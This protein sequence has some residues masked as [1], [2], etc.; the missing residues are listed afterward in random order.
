MQQMGRTEMIKNNL[1]PCFERPFEIEYRFDEVQM[2]RFDVY[3][4]D[5]DTDK[6]TDDDFL[7]RLDT[8]VEQVCRKHASTD[9]QSL[10]DR[11]CT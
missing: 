3:D 2:I 9:R 5:N 7:G 8:S 6:L 4:I 10:A 1:N 11:W